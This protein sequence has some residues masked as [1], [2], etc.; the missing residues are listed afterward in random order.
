MPQPE[1]HSADEIKEA[2]DQR[3]ERENQITRWHSPGIL[4]ILSQLR[5][6]R[7]DL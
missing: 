3:G 2:D 6:Q 5:Q 4:A 1:K 7:Q